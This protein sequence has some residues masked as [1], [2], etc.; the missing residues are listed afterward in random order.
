[1]HYEWTGNTGVVGARHKYILHDNMAIH[2]SL[3]ASSSQFT[4]SR[5]IYQPDGSYIDFEYAK[6]KTSLLSFSSVMTQKFSSRLSLRIGAVLS[7]ISYNIVIRAAESPGDPVIE[8][9]AEDGVTGYLQGF[10]QL[11][12]VVS[13]SFSL[14]GGLHSML[15]FLNHSVTLEPRLGITYKF[16]NGNSLGLAYGNHSQIEPLPAY[17]Y[18]YESLAGGSHKPNLGL[19]PSRSNHVVGSY[20]RLLAENL[21]LTAE[22]YYQRLYNIPVTPGGYY[23][24]L[25]FKQEYLIKDSLSNEGTGTNMGVDLTVERFLH[26]NYY[27]LVTGS[28]ID[29]KYS[30]GDNRTYNTR[31]DYGYVLNLLGGREFFLG[32]N[33]DKI[34]GIN[35]R[36]VFQG[37][38][39]THPVDL[40]KSIEAQDV[41]YDVD[42][43]WED[44]FP[45]TYFID[46]TATLRVNKPRYASIWGIQIKNLLLENSIFYHQFNRKDQVV[47]ITGEGFIFPN[48]SYKI[49]F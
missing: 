32:K 46:F 26:R 43:A 23:A 31:W 4:D 29:S 7:R 44:R 39:R 15:F 24:L 11:K 22:I 17:F 19:V 12:W 9:D 14:T 10:S 5:E 37:G 34:M 42:R 48:I 41:V 40:E 21:R 36:M 30:T 33:R 1:M 45:N 38:E 27:F 28:I 47:E 16:L 18:Q 3:T 6:N 20:N 49:E 2:T 8:Y 35:A 13:P 25:N